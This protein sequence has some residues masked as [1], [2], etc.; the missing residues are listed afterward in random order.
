MRVRIPGIGLMG[1]PTFFFRA[2]PK[3]VADKLSAD[4]MYFETAVAAKLMVLMNRLS[5]EQMNGKAPIAESDI[6]G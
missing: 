1:S 2:D 6:F 3:G 5:V 4:V